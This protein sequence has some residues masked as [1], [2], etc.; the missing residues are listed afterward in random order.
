M[1]THSSTNFLTQNNL[2]ANSEKQVLQPKLHK[3]QHIIK[4]KSDE[5]SRPALFKKPLQI[6]LNK[7]QSV[8]ASLLCTSP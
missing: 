4:M 3:L 2:R 6:Q 1:H 5:A 7:T 8:Y